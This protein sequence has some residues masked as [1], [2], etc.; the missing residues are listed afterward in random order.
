LVSAARRPEVLAWLG[1]DRGPAAAAERCC[2]VE[3]RRGETTVGAVAAWVTAARTAE[4][5][6][7]RLAGGEVDATCQR[8]FTILHAE[9]HAR[10]VRVAYVYAPPA[11][12]HV[13]ERLAAGGFMRAAD[14][15][16]LAR[17]GTIAAATAS[18]TDRAVSTRFRELQFVAWQPSEHQRLYEVLRATQIESRDLPAFRGAL[19]VENLVAGYAETGDAG[20]THWR[21]AVYVQGAAT[22]DVGCLLLADHLEW[23]RLELMYMGLIPT[24]R[25]RGWG[26]ALVGQA[27]RLASNLG[28]AQI[29]A[30]VDAA[31]D[32]AIAVYAAAGFVEQD[33]KSV[34]LKM[35]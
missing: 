20:W 5:A 17:D 6:P 21:I 35:F 18:G 34:W 8:L 11:E 2:L 26:H 13:A 9:L 23:A 28:R 10:Q 1:Q 29:I 7:P 19:A 14:V 27:I 24:A 31:N 33:R 3:A 4:V 12:V 32:P 15:L 16:V 22:T 30:A 25:G